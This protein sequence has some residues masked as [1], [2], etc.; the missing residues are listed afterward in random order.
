MSTTY[1]R[2]DASGTLDQATRHRIADAYRHLNPVRLRQQLQGLQE[3]IW[4]ASN[5][6]QVVV[7]SKM[8]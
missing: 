6:A 7:R 5:D 8:T 4:A 2:L 1:Q 3:Q